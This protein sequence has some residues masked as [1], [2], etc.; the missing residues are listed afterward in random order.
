MHD[1]T[2][3]NITRALIAY[4][5]V[6]RDAKSFWVRIGTASMGRDGSIN[7]KLDAIPINGIVVLRDKEPR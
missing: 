1:D 4:T 5:V 6:E 2:T 7:V 3:D